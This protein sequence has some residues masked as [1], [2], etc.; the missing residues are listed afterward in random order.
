[1]CSSLFF[2]SSI[3]DKLIKDAYIHLDLKINDVN[4]TKVNT[5]LKI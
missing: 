2:F 4:K 1:M 3:W 5:A